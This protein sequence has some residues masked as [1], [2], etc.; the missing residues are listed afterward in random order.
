M[1]AFSPGSFSPVPGDCRNLSLS[2]ASSVACEPVWQHGSAAAGQ[3]RRWLGLFST[4][5]PHLS[6][7]PF[8]GGSEYLCDHILWTRGRERTELSGGFSISGHPFCSWLP[9]AEAVVHPAM[10]FQLSILWSAG[11]IQLTS[12]SCW[13]RQSPNKKIYKT[14]LWDLK[15]KNYVLRV[16][17]CGV[18]YSVWP[19]RRTPLA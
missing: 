17:L 10:G 8:P 9:V 12:P 5:R 1:P 19:R 16:V 7:S 14:F 6:D 18:L 11:Q 13:F 4:S 3:G 2:G 15:E